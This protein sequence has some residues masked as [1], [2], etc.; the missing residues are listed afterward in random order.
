MV[1]TRS[2]PQ[3]LD[4]LA[5]AILGKDGAGKVQNTPAATAAHVTQDGPCWIKLNR[6]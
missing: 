1:L 3:K 6:S 2:L 5:D 4:V